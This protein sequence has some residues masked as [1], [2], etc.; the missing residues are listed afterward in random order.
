[1]LFHGIS[2]THRRAQ[3]NSLRRR[4]G[5]IYEALGNVRAQTIIAETLSLLSRSAVQHVG[6]IVKTIGDA[7][8]CQFSAVADAMKASVEMQQCV[9]RATPTRDV[10]VK[11]LAIRI[12]FHYGRVITQ[13]GDVF[14]DAANIAAHVVARAKPG[15]ILV[16]KQTVRAL[17]NHASVRFVDS[18]HG[19]GKKVP[20]ELFEIVW[21]H[22]DLTDV[23]G[24]VQPE[25]NKTHL[26]VT[27]SNKAIELGD[28][29][30]ILNM[31]R[32]I[33]N[34]VVV[35]DPVAS[36]L[37]ARI[38]RRHDRF[39][40]VDQSLNGTYLRMQG[41]DGGGAPQERNRSQRLRG[42]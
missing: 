7:L 2:R 25:L 1:M 22:R 39:V 12:G 24:F 27:F 34:D 15:Q 29:R 30:P 14:G 36:R 4:V 21:D 11:P 41:G 40:L 8:M 13:G 38:E 37:H 31:G 19:E 28:N 23:Q 26:T 9:K 5:C 20:L 42:D 35:S 16:S 3:H 18:I 10:G 6:T 17:R 32:G 33:E